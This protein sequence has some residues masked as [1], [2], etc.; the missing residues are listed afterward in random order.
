[1]RIKMRQQQ[2]KSL[3][4]AAVVATVAILASGCAIGNGG[5]AD[6]DTERA[7]LISGF[8]ARPAT[9]AAQRQELR[10]MPDDQF[11]K[12]TQDGNTYYLYPDKKDNRLY[13]GDYYA[14]RAYRGYLKNKHLRE[15]GVFVWETN[16]ADRAN[17]RTVEVWH[18]WTPFNQWR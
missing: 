7:L 9:T 8:K 2:R 16:P 6:T 13:A 14:Y 18:D 11:A 10:K 1:M 17:N 4:S 15:Q 3:M 12:V 5:I